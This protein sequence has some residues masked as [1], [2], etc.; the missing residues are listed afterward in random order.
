MRTSRCFFRVRPREEEGQQKSEGG[1]GAQEKNNIELDVEQAVGE[2]RMIPRTLG[3]QGHPV[4]MRLTGLTSLTY[5]N[6]H[7]SLRVFRA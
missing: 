4:R 1:G 5:R 3:G 6:I 7:A 2:E